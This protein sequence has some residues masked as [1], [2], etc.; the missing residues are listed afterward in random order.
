MK[1]LLVVHQFLPDSIAGTEVLVSDVARTLLKR[2]HE[3]M[4]FAG[5]RGEP[6]D[7]SD[8]LSYRFQDYVVQRV[9]TNFVASNLEERLRADHNAHVETSFRKLLDSWKPDV[10]H[11][12]HLHRMSTALVDI[13]AMRCKV[14]F[15]ATDFWSIC[16]F[17]TLR[18]PDGSS[19]SGPSAGLTNCIRHHAML[20]RPKWVRQMARRIPGSAIAASL[21]LARHLPVQPVRAAL[22]L[23]QR[24]L[25]VRS[26]FSKV[27]RFFFASDSIGTMLC[28]TGV[29]RSRLTKQPYGVD[30]D[31]YSDIEPPNRTDQF[32]V[33]FIG[34]LVEHKGI[35]VLLQAMR[36]ITS[37]NIRLKV[38]GDFSGTK[39]FITSLV[40]L[41]GNDERISF[42]GVF[43]PMHIRSILEGLDCLVV[44]STWQEN[45]PLVACSALA[46]RRAVIA[47]DV[48]GLRSVVHPGRNGFLFAPG[49]SLALASI[50][51]ELASAPQLLSQL[52]METS[53]L[54]TLDS[55][56]D[57]LIGHYQSEGC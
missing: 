9:N 36:L 21:H 55:Y 37:P 25:A 41:K 47:S 22:A 10:I 12:F 44:P 1:V 52:S 45:M 43:P 49:D 4:V 50:L 18:L 35:D 11:F 34:Q 28:R 48:P 53:G 6:G 17:G 32:R 29:C 15:T 40:T 24:P 57:E 39:E 19:C 5:V 46:A 42:E 8:D 33:G 54:R 13:G 3:V 7:D 23:R 2:G 16:A 51:S 26:A 20:V 31:A 27:Q 30:L 38:Y 56:V 14:F